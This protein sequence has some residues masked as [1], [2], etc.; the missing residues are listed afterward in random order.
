MEIII[1]KNIRLR[2]YQSKDKPALFKN[3]TDKKFLKFMEY[4]KFSIT[5]FNSWL[6]IKTKNSQGRTKSLTYRKGRRRKTITIKQL[7]K[8]A[9]FN[10]VKSAW[11]TK[12]KTNS[13][14][15][16]FYGKGHGH[17][18][19]LCQWGAYGLAKSGVSAKRILKRYYP[20]TT[21]RRIQ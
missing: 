3:S 20:N 17:G 11:L 12:I 15:V 2:L 18:V 14:Y 6:K 9:G 16:S 21:I 1:D 10:N 8:I 13:Q 4:K 7:Q 5:K 19:G